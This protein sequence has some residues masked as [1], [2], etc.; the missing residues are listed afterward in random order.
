V[1]EKSMKSIIPNIPTAWSEKDEKNTRFI[2]KINK[3]N[4][5]ITCQTNTK[6]IPSLN[7]TRFSLILV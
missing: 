2:P 7:Q 4:T 6:I 3:I 5:A 1:A